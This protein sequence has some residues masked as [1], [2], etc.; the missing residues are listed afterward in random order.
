MFLASTTADTGVGFGFLVAAV[1]I[2]VIAYVIS[3]KLHPETN[4]HRCKGTG[5]HWGA[6]FTYARRQCTYCGGNGRK[7]RL[8]TR[9]LR[10]TPIRPFERH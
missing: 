2:Y 8:G 3:L 6:I 10:P 1:L 5:R 4:C 9:I 7:P